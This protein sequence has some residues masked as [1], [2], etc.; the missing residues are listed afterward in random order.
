MEGREVMGTSGPDTLN[1]GMHDDT[2]MGGAG[3]DWLE[4]RGGADMLDGGEG[5]DWSNYYGS[6]AAVAVDLGPGG[7]NRGGE[8]EGD[9][10][11]SIE[12]LAGS[13]H[14]DNL[15]LAA[16][17]R[18]G[19]SARAGRTTS[20]AAPATTASAAAMGD[21]E[22]LGGSLATT[23]SPATW[24]RTTSTGASGNDMLYGGKG[25]DNAVRRGRHGRASKAATAPT[26]WTAA[27]AW[28]TPATRSRTR[29]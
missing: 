7:I 29:A 27:R 16:T 4:G 18:T 15:K 8:A 25:D 24:G 28:T 5:F 17:G 22:L 3:D 9:V 11:R 14:N 1:G 23:C 2:L 10:L 26:R 20:M 6:D 13:M 12:G 19:C 21:D